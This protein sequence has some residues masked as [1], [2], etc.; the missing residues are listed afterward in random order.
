[1]CQQIII[2]GTILN[3]EAQPV[4]GATISIKGKSSSVVSRADGSFSLP[5]TSAKDTLLVSA[6]GYE[7]QQL[8]NNERGLHTIIL[9]RKITQLA[10]VTVNTGY[11]RIPKERSTGSF[12]FISNE[13]LSRAVG[14]GILERLEGISS[15]YFDRRASSN[16]AIS[17]R[18]RS[19]LFGNASPLI[20]VDN[21]PFESD[22]SNIN[23]NDVESITLLK[24]AAAASIWGARAANGVLVITTKKGRYNLKPSTQFNSN[25]TVTEK[26]HL[27]YNPALPS[28]DFIGVETFLF[29]NGFYNAAL[30]NTTT[31]PALSPVAE[32]LAAQR[33]G[34]IS[35]AEAE[36]KINSLKNKDLRNDLSRYFYRQAVNQQYALS[37]TGGTDNLTYALS[38]GYDHNQSALVKNNNNRFSLRSQTTFR[39]VNWV[40]LSLGI[41][42]TKSELGSAN[43]AGSLWAGSGGFVYPYAQLVD[44]N[45]NPLPLIKDYRSGFADTAGNGKLLDWK[46]RPYQELNEAN[47]KTTIAEKRI[48]TAIDFRVNR[49]FTVNL[50]Y[51]LQQ[52]HT[53]RLNLYNTNTYLTRDLINLYY[54]P[55]TNIYNVPNGSIM[56][57]GNTTLNAH[58]GRMQVNFARLWKSKHQLNMIAGAEARQTLATSS[59][60]RVYGYNED[61]RTFTNV[62]FIDKLP[63]YAGLRS[64]RPIPNPSSFSK[65]V[66]RFLS[67]YTN[68]SYTLNKKYIL[69][70]SAR[71]DASNIFG[72][73]TNQKWVPLWSSGFA[74]VISKEKFYRWQSIP[75][76]RLRLTYGYNGNIDNSMAAITTIRYTTKALF[77]SLPYAIIQNTPN[78]ELRWEKTAVLNLAYDFAVKN[79]RVK[80]SLEYFI[81]KGTGLIGLAPIDPTTGVQTNGTFTYKGNVAAM[82]ATGVEISLN[83]IN[84][85]GS[86]KWSTTLTGS[87]LSSKVTGYKLVNLNAS[88]FINLGQTIS[89]LPGKY[90]YSIYSQKWAGIDPLT[91]DPQGY[92]NSIVSKDYTALVNVNVNELAYHGSAVPLVFG[93]LLNTFSWQQF[94]VS[95]NLVY[96][97]HYYFMRPSVNYNELFNNM[98]AH[99]DYNKRWQKPGDELHTQVPSL[100]YPNTNTNR[101]YFYNTS[102]ILVEKGDHIRLQD[103]SVSYSLKGLSKNTA[104]KNMVLYAYINNVGI[105][106]RANKRGIDPDY[107]SVGYPL[108]RSYSFG[109]KTAF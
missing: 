100:V 27:W 37:Y 17:I 51:Q 23:P 33:A 40:E 43:P 42:L 75:Y 30:S 41:T 11:Q 2:Q 81:K 46:Y 3:E 38:A 6:I 8:P 96:K 15:I 26:P 62:N 7:T 14:S 24:D 49:Y 109:I 64:A 63:I 39:P 16:G 91:G 52:Q 97:L 80:G 65:D 61:V 77:T 103:I 105:I 36:Q 35:S 19:T 58:T 9:K 70:L 78:P 93:S 104:I 59:A 83:T 5:N 47:N 60:Y 55:V 84:T 1:M 94:T 102:S 74:W 73:N 67:F 25:I 32:I 13:Q 45:R 72:V 69:S 53:N 85:I 82:K 12:E 89:P 76:S 92:L 99:P 106:W 31:W 28:E 88:A 90:L 29:S 107:F 86:F 101:D 10:E 4:E 20:V 54:N 21:V 108:P 79:E 95:A 66:L 22:L 50:L 48:N 44:E 71:K 34:T 56:D 98:N 68:G 87:Y 57:Q 18:G